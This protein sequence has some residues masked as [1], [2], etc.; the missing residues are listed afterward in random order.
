VRH[1]L[2]LSLLAC[3][4]PIVLDDAP[5]TFSPGVYTGTFQLEMNASF[6]LWES[7]TEQCE[8]DFMVIVE[9]D[10]DVAPI[11]GRVY[12]ETPTLGGNILDIK[13]DLS[14]F[15]EIYGELSSSTR[16]D[17]WG[18]WFIDE[19]CLFAEVSGSIEQNGVT[20]DYAGDFSACL[21]VEALPPGVT[22]EPELSLDE[23]PF[24]GSFLSQ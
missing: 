16:A 10:H 7:A 12:C 24:D 17:S 1:L 9:P 13:G 23:E 19:E 11:R 14:S 18:G 21:D 6:G 5:Q 2:S 4:E 20:V 15:P 8:S 22:A 3:G